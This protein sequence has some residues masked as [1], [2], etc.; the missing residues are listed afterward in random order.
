VIAGV[1][2]REDATRLVLGCSRASIKRCS[3]H[4]EIAGNLRSGFT[5]F[6]QAHSASNLTVGDPAGSAAKVLS[7]FSA[8]ADGVGD[9][10]AFDLVF[11][12]RESGHDREQHQPHGC[13]GVDVTTAEVQEVQAPASTAKFVSEGEHVLGGSPEPIHRR[14]DEGVSVDQRV[15]CSIELGS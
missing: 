11:H 6:D 7:G 9:A 4:S 8:F 15:E 2:F 13:R 3:G 12:L 14:D 1:A 5:A 10:F